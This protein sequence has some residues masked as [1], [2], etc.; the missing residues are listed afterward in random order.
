MRLTATLAIF[1]A[2]LLAGCNSD[3]SD[4]PAPPANTGSTTGTGSPASVTSISANR[5]Q[6]S[7]Q[8]RFTITG[9]NLDQSISLNVSAC[10]NLAEVT[11]NTASQ[12]IY[13]C[14]I[15]G[16][17]SLTAEVKSAS[18]ASLYKA[19]QTV[20]MPQVSMKTSLGDLVVELYPDKAPIS[21]ANFMSYV[22]SGFYNGL[23]FH[24]VEKEFV[25]QGGGKSATGVIPATQ[26]PIKLEVGKG[27]SNLRGTI[28]MARTNVLDSATS[29]F[30][31]NTVDNIPLDTYGGGY[32]VFGKITSGLTVIDQI[33]LVP[34]DS[35]A[36]PLTPVVI[37][38]VSQ[39]Q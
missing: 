26:P 11:G 17:G 27:L 22:N 15:S 19:Q 7:Q 28:A 10:S 38:S 3:G 18:G 1:G 35:K 24:R 32:A 2:A 20:P 36:Q 23:I 8:S 12:R 6:Y 21:V 5:L 33:N 14:T 13:T 25:V 31:F 16:V 34:T 30:Y 39:I 37:N 9:Q 4:D 29:Q